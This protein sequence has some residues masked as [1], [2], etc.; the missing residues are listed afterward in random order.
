MGYSLQVD[1]DITYQVSLSF[2]KCTNIP[3]PS[4]LILLIIGILHG[5]IFYFSY[6]L[7]RFGVS[8]N[9]DIIWAK[10]VI[11]PLILNEFWMT[12][13]G[14][15]WQVFVCEMSNNTMLRS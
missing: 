10:I 7:T 3:L 9:G 12:H 2:S 4:L 14:G 1:S 13:Q 11:F 6:P 8:E 15:E 5:R